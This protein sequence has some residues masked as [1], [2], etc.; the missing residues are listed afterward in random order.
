MVPTF[1]T[2]R[3]ARAGS[4]RSRAAQWR[5][6]FDELTRFIADEGRQPHWRAPVGSV[7]RRLYTWLT[8]QRVALAEGRLDPERHRRLV[9]AG[10]LANG[11]CGR[12]WRTHVDSLL[13][14]HRRTGRLPRPRA[15]AGNE[16]ELWRFYEQA[17]HDP[18]FAR[19]APELAAAPVE[20]DHTATVDH[21]RSA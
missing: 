12:R 18:R 1:D 19:M 21:R 4:R 16:H 3:K 11:I 17:R 8:A 2:A 9:D 6:H 13:E 10:A 14:F 15:F 5:A 7:E 20:A